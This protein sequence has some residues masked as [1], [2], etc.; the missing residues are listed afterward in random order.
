MN[1]T[2][3]VAVSEEL[4]PLSTGITLAMTCVGNPGHPP[5][6]L[7]HGGG[8]T[9]HAWR[10]TAGA[11]AKAGWYALAVDHRGH[12]ESSW[13]PDGSYEND[14]FRDDLLDL[15]SQLSQPPVLV[16]ASLGGVASLLAADALPPGAVRA[17]VFVDITPRLE[18]TGVHRILAF[19]NARPDG[20]DTLEEVAD[21]V[22]A[23]QPHRPRPRALEGLRKNL[24]VDAAGRFR[25]HWD[26]KLLETW[27]P[28]KWSAERSHRTVTRR[29]Q[30]AARLSVPVLLV[31]G[32]MSDVVSEANAQ[33]F[34]QVVPHAVYVDLAGASHMVAGDRNDVF[35]QS[36]LSFLDGLPQGAAGASGG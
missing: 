33:E 10:G 30:A 29:M 1:D 5:V 9:R 32:R 13:D 18:P 6:V 2:R 17:L 28:A 12:G 23:Y 11:L 14:D 19:M 25:W 15:L 20:F 34:L 16:G 31:R 27:D 35:T 3:D 4:R 24:R 22:A 7:L 26:P 21:A 8:Q 36:V